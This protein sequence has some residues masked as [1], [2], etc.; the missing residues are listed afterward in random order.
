MMTFG[1]AI[2]E[3]RKGKAIARLGWN[4]KNMWVTVS[5]GAP[6]LPSM[7]FWSQANREYA[8]NRPDR[9]A[10]VLP[11]FTMRTAQGDI[12]MGWLASQTDMLA[13]DWQ[14]VEAK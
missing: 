3:A 14:V 8:E 1:Q 10:N 4:G 11:C 9:C 13:S 7:Q 2:E 12:L 5:P 6:N